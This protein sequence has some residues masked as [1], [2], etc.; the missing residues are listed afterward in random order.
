LVLA[1]SGRA[2]ATI[3]APLQQGSGSLMFRTDGKSRGDAKELL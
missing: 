1:T 3:R 2:R